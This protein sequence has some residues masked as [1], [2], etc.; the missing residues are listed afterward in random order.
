MTP[1]I[2]EMLAV[3][4]CEPEQA[5]T[6]YQTYL[7]PEHGNIK[8]VL[9]SSHSELYGGDIRNMKYKPCLPLEEFGL[10]QEI[11]LTPLKSLKGLSRRISALSNICGGMS[12]KTIKLITPEIIFLDFQPKLYCIP[13]IFPSPNVAPSQFSS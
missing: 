7:I 10:V 9:L 4:F 13:P 11:K 3:S 1:N 12:N 2:P 6:A 5:D 8:T